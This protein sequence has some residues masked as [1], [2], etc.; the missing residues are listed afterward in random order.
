MRSKET[1]LGE[2]DSSYANVKG[3]ETLKASLKALPHVVTSERKTELLGKV[4]TFCPQVQFYNDRA[5]YDET[6][7]RKEQNGEGTPA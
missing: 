4:Q 7:L 1:I 6:E 5:Y 3:I 2:M